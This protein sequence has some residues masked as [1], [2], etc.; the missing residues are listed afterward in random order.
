MAKKTKLCRRSQSKTHRHELG[1]ESNTFASSDRLLPWRLGDPPAF[2]DSLRYACMDVGFTKRAPPHGMTKQMAFCSAC[3][4]PRCIHGG[5]IDER[6]RKGQLA[7]TRAG[8]TSPIFPPFN[9]PGRVRDR[10]RRSR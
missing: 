3:E 9:A 7:L 4:A 6:K 1:A 8:L 5:P 2:E 10:L